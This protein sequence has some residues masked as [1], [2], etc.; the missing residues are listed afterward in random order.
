MYIIEEIVRKNHEHVGTGENFMNRTPMVYA[1][2]STI[3]KWDFIKLKGFYKAK[4]PVTMTK[5]QPAD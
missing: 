5:W 1:L 3:D 4:D 2:R